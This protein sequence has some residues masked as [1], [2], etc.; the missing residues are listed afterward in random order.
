MGRKV[1][2]QAVGTKIIYEER[3]MKSDEITS[4]NSMLL[5][6]SDKIKKKN[7][8]RRRKIEVIFLM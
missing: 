2:F 8:L 1:S 6:R 7:H 3:M 4:S 5:T